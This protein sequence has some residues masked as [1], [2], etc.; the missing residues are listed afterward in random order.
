MN[1]AFPV[2]WILILLLIL[3]VVGA[4]AAII[5]R[6]W[7]AG[8]VVL[9][10]VLL[11]AGLYSMRAVPSSPTGMGMNQES[12]T[13]ASQQPE[14]I[15]FLKTA[16]IYPSTAEAAKFLALRVCDDI[17]R[18]E[19]PISPNDI[20]IV[21]AKNDRTAEI[22]SETFRDEF[23]QA[24]VVADDSHDGNPSQLMVVLSVLNSGKCLNL[25]ATQNGKTLKE[26]ACIQDAP[27]VSSLDEYRDKNAKGEWVVGSSSMGEITL[28]T[29]K[30]RAREDAANKII[31]LI[32]ARSPELG[33]A[34]PNWLCIRLQQELTHH[35]FVKDEFLQI[36]RTPVV[37]TTVY[38]A[39]VLVDASSSQLHSSIL[40]E[41]HHRNDHAHRFGGGVVGMGLVI[42]LVY[43]FLNRATR[44]Y[45]QMNLRLA[46]FLVLVAG[47]LMLMLIG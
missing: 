22:I 7:I 31:P 24:K 4:L 34:D 45:F 14:L 15:D 27:W 33:T 39:A 17:H 5:W 36:M 35:R 19:P 12:A 46:A 8:S 38:H 41:F 44:G 9:L 26:E 16:N 1:S 2:A 11:I 30:Q 10:V 20:H 43:L 32:I 18:S 37:G 6:S 47:V 40:S 21:S 42:C 28:E 29:A 13:P 3:I 23:P 25:R